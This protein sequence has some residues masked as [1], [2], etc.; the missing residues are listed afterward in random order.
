MASSEVIELSADGAFELPDPT[1]AGPSA[2]GDAAATDD[3][4]ALDDGTATEDER[5]GAARAARPRSDAHSSNVC[6]AASTR[7][8]AR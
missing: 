6:A 4:T 7:T 8:P 3:S 2:G 1:V 5:R